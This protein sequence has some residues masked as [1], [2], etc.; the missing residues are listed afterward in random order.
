M[1][2]RFAELTRAK[3]GF[4]VCATDFGLI[5]FLS[6]TIQVIAVLVRILE[7]RLVTTYSPTSVLVVVRTPTARWDGPL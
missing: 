7:F 5:P 6:T 3:R 1:H 4:A 2:G